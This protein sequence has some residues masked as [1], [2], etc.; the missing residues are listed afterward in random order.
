MAA[1]LVRSTRN[2]LCNNLRPWLQVEIERFNAGSRSHRF[3]CKI[4][5]LF[6]FGTHSFFAMDSTRRKMKWSLVRVRCNCLLKS[7]LSVK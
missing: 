3:A 2:L 5:L 1:A 7:C 6:R 4:E